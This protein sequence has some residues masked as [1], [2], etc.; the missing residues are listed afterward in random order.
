[1]EGYKLET[2]ED[3]DPKRGFCVGPTAESTLAWKLDK[4]DREADDGWAFEICLV[5]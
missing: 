4:P 1:M 3:A 5:G 2:S